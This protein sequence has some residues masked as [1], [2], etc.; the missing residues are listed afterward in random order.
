MTRLILLSAGIFF[1][2]GSMSH[3]AW[4]LVHMKGGGQ[5]LTNRYWVEGP[6]VRF[7]MEEG[8]VGVP[9]E[10]VLRI[11]PVSAPQRLYALAAASSRLASETTSAGQPETTAQQPSQAASPGAAVLEK[12][13]ADVNAFDEKLSQ[14]PL[15]FLSKED[16]RSLASA[17]IELRQKMLASRQIEPLTPL[18]RK[19]D[20]RL[21]QLEET[22]TQTR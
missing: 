18:L 20:D 2:T 17:G 22:L 3:A 16:I 8:V 6:E 11:E 19:L 10:E 14:K 13:R 1:L 5:Y 4:Y 7:E 15:F 12:F 9:H 21:D